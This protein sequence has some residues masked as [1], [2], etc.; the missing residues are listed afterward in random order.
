MIRQAGQ[1]LLK[2]PHVLARSGQSV[3]NFAS[4]AHAPSSSRHVASGMV[5]R[6]SALRAP[7]KG[8][9]AR[10]VEGGGDFFP[11]R[12]ATRTASTNGRGG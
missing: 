2:N 10:R 11:Q 7:G 9:M 1:R 12:T 5:Q 8:H 4:G 3:R 6:R